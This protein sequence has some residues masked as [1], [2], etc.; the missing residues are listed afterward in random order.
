MNHLEMY[1]SRLTTPGE[2]AALVPDGSKLLLP[3]GPA[4]PP[5]LCEA[6]A[7]RAEAGGLTD[8][9][10]MY[11]HSTEV[12]TRTLLQ[13][14]LLDIFH[15]RAPY[16]GPCERRIRDHDVAENKKRW[17]Y[18]PAYF[19]RIPDIFINHIG[20]DTFIL[21]VSPMDRHGYFSV[22]ISHDYTAEMIHQVPNLIV[23]VNEHMPRTF[24]DGFLHVSR[25]AAIVENS[26]PLH[27]FPSKEPTEE[28]RRIAAYIA[29][30]VPDRAT[31]QFG[32][33]SVPDSVCE[34]LRDHRDLGIHSELISPALA[35]LIQSGAV[36]NRY[37]VLNRYKSVFTVILADRPT[38]DFIHDNPAVEGYAVS[39]VNDPSVISQFDSMISVNGVMQVDLTG[40][41][42]S[43]MVGR[44]QFSGVGG[45]TDF[46]RGAR[47]SKGGK[48][49]L[50]TRSTASHGTVSKIVPF[51]EEAVTD[52]RMDTQY[53]V[54]E[55]G[56]ADLL[57]KSTIERALALINIAHPKFREELLHKAKEM[58]LVA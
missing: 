5:A 10:L 36:T 7:Q 35:R 15:P 46:I 22:G 56:V 31:V 52:T 43:E 37:K 23:E 26:S 25:V 45:Q 12:L 53:I 48:S 4:I 41:A 11:M 27:E 3:F 55:F 6:L 49:I 20:F 40:Q 32:V 28:D 16:M 13:D 30:M 29:E 54:T 9:Y 24:G 58:G 57:G 51:I 44:R 18:L 2:A 14:H 50:A 19:H 42:N 47:A 17:Q 21:Q 39:Y 8:M 1:R 33:G 34:V 38:Y